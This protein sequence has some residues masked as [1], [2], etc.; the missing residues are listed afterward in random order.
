M[1]KYQTSDANNHLFERHPRFKRMPLDKVD[2]TASKNYRYICMQ[3]WYIFFHFTKPRFSN[4]QSNRIHF[5][6]IDIFIPKL[7]K[8]S[9]HKVR[10]FHV[11][12]KESC[13]ALQHT[14]VLWTNLKWKMSFWINAQ[15]HKSQQHSHTWRKSAFNWPREGKRMGKKS[16]LDENQLQ[17]WMICRKYFIK[18]VLKSASIN[19]QCAS[20]F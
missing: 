20:L 9:M 10:I 18:C 4:L 7:I 2:W 19:F 6:C 5:Y 1:S 8:N 17:L 12:S 16:C 3:H 15:A 11:V 13:T 14:Y